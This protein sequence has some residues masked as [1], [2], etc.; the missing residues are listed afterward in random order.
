MN[1]PLQTCRSCGEVLRVTFCDLGMTPLSNSFLKAKQLKQSEAFYPLHAYVCEAC[2]LVQLEEYESPENIFSDYVYFSSYSQT[3]LEHARQYTEMMVKRFG[4][5]PSSRVIE[6]ASNDGYLLK[7]FKERGFQILGIEP[8]KNVAQV[9]EDSGIPMVTDF[10]GIALAEQLV[11]Q[12]K[13]ADLLLGNN[14][15]AHVPDLHDFVEG[16]RILLKA[17]GILTLEFP[18]VLRLMDETQFDTIYHEHFSYFSLVAL[19]KV[20]EKHGLVLFDVEELK[21]HGGSLRIF[22]KHEGA[23]SFPPSESLN[24]VR[25]LEVAAGLNRLEAYE[26]FS[27]KVRDKKREI[28]TA[29]I[30]LKQEGKSIVVYGAAA[31]GNTLLNYCGIGKDFIDYAVD[32]NPA[33]QGCF[34]PG[35]HIQVFPPERIRETKPD[36]LFILPWN[37]QNEIMDQMSLIRE[38]GGR[39]VVPLPKL[40]IL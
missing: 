37:I 30:D 11:E 15:L 28:I 17:D 5:A 26:T 10:F 38:W 25:E 23:K 22:V 39:F 8:A 24:R 13:Q 3:W 16:L 29:L 6:V 40:K 21:T 19:E 31:K 1:I 27:Q 35:T 34:L 4:L 36:Y 33:K 14:V 32:R 12:K 9:A 18:H 2:F 7:N 20:F